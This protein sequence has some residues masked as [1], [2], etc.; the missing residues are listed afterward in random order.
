LDWCN[1]VDD[2]CDGQTDEYKLDYEVCDGVD[3][4]CNGYSDNDDPDLEV[5]AY[6]GTL[7]RVLGECGLG[8]GAKCMEI[9]GIFDWWCDYPATVDLVDVNNPNLIAAQEVRCDGL[10]ND[11]DGATDESFLS[12]VKQ[13]PCSADVGFGDTGICLS[14]GYYI[15]D[16]TDPYADPVCHIE[17]DGVP[18]E[19]EKCNGLDDNCDGQTDEG[20]IDDFIHIDQN[21]FDFYIYKYEASR[22]DAD[23]ESGGLIATRSCSKPEVIPWRG[24]VYQQAFDACAAAGARLCADEEWS[25]ACGGSFGYLYPYGDIYEAGACNGVDYDGGVGE[26]LPTG[27]LADCKSSYDVFDISGNLR[28]WTTENPSPDI[29]VLRGGSFNTPMIGLT[30]EFKTSQAKDDVILPAVGFRCCKDAD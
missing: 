28:E 19:S 5:P 10:D 15:C 8:E 26:A 24:A 12:V 14:T 22:I 27:S 30:C 29:H 7:C 21:G 4:D 13:Q 1:D 20:D 9:D 17:V 3:N 16:E 11:C 6:V 23:G 2:D 25:E 18:A